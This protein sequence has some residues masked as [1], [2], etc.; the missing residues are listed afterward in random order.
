MTTENL[1]QDE[2]SKDIKRS[3]DAGNDPS[4]NMQSSDQPTDDYEYDTLTNDRLLKDHEYD[5]IRELD[6]SPP[7]WFNMLFIGTVLFAFFYLYILWMF[8]PSSLVQQKEYEKEMAAVRTEKTTQAAVPRARLELALLTDEVSLANGKQI[9]NNVCAVCH[10]VDGAGLVGPN[11]TDQYW[12][13]GNTIKDLYTV[14]T[15]GVIEKGMI[16]YRDQLSA[17]QRLEVSSFILQ[18]IVGTQPSNP[19]AP[20]GELIP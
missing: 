18:N 15:E 11:L 9:Y 8:E 4:T 7:S 17:R 1:P 16:P 2:S 13:H 14:V 12:I 19:K 5:G 20:E 6:N 10:L 3:K